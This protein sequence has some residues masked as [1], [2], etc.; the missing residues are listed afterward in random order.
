MAVHGPS[1]VIDG[2]YVGDNKWLRSQGKTFTKEDVLYTITTIHDRENLYILIIW[3][4]GPTW[5][6]SID[7]RFE[8]DGDSH[9]HNLATGRTDYKYNGA[10]MDGPSSFNDGHFMGGGNETI[11][12]E[13]VGTYSDG[14][15]VQEW[16]VPLKGTDPG[17]INVDNF[18]TT[19]GFVVLDWG[20]GVTTGIWPPGADPYE[21]ETWGNLELL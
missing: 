3:E 19:L 21:P 18:P 7:I 4:S 8:Q 9:D 10:V 15:W 14:K 13:V 11:N 1:P 12:G 5:N 20:S 2:I 17:D 16:V 6:N